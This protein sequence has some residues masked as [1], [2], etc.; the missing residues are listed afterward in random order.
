ME[1][2]VLLDKANTARALGMP[3]AELFAILKTSVEVEVNKTG[4]IGGK[5]KK[6]AKIP[7]RT[8]SKE[9]VLLLQKGILILYFLVCLAISVQ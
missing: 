8:I 5:V 4:R 3:L 2:A 6:V 1:D 7:I 9:T